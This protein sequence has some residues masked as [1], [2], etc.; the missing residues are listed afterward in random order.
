MKGGEGA[1]RETRPRGKGGGGEKK[2]LS[3]VIRIWGRRLN[4][5]TREKKRGSRKYNHDR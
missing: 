1:E 5:L 4:R 3:V 2:S